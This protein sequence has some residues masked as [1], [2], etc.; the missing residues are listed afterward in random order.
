VSLILLQTALCRSGT[1]NICR[2]T[3]VANP[4]FVYGILHLLGCIGVAFFEP[5]AAGYPSRCDLWM[6]GGL[7]EVDP[8]YPNRSLDKFEGGSI[9]GTCEE[10]KGI[11]NSERYLAVLSMRWSRD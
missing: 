10:N 7:G 1:R 11:K 5:R 3:N 8:N 4:L 2:E 6:R 9:R